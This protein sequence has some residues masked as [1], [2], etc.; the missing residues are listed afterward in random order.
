M[1]NK[2][3][4]GLA[5]RLNHAICAGLDPGTFILT[6][7]KKLLTCGVLLSLRHA[8]PETAKGQLH[9]LELKGSI[10]MHK[11]IEMASVLRMEAVVD[12]VNT[13]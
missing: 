6:T 5:E 9:R 3:P 11:A 2:D 1:V 13:I 10:D 12:H 7:S 4:R 8:R